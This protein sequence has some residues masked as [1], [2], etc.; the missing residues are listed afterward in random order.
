LNITDGG[1]DVSSSG[2]G[3]DRPNQ[4]GAAYTSTSKTTK[5]WFAPG[6]FQKQ[7]AGTFGNV[8]R[9]SL[10]GPNALNL[11]AAISRTFHI[12]EHF[13]YLFRADAFNALNHPVWS[14]PTTSV[15]SSN[16]GKITSFGSPRIL[17][18]GSKLIF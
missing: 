10:Y 11:D 17:Q 1:V 18:I 13:S 4:I 5:Q 3:N 15:T 6:A 14:N 2:Q 9:D 8:G 12:R 16:F 7:A